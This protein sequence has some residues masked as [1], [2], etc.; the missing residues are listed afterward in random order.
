MRLIFT[1][2]TQL[3]IIAELLAATLLSLSCIAVDVSEQIEEM[4]HK[5][6]HILV[7]ILMTISTF[8]FMVSTQF[9]L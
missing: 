5:R 4:A 7:L 8:T 6:D 1:T 2:S 9:K 3:F